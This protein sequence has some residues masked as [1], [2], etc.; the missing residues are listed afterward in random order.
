MALAAEMRMSSEDKKT[1]AQ[2]QDPQL[3]NGLAMALDAAQLGIWELDFASGNIRRSLKHDQIFGYDTLQPTW[4][5]MDSWRH[6]RPEDKAAVEQSYK[7]AL[8]TGFWRAHFYIDRNDGESRPITLSATVLYDVRGKPERMIGVISEDKDINRDTP[9]SLEVLA[10]SEALKRSQQA[11]RQNEHFTQTVLNSVADGVVVYDRDL[12]Y[13][14]WNRAMSMATGISSEQIIGRNVQEVFPQLLAEGV[15]DLLHRALQGENIRSGDRPFIVP[16]TGEK[17][18]VQSIFSPHFDA[19]GEIIGVV[20]II[21]NVTERRLAEENLIKLKS[22][23]IARVQAE[24]AQHKISTILQSITDAFFAIDN[25]FRFTYVNPRAAQFLR[26][27]ADELLGQDLREMFPT[28]VEHEDFHYLRKAMETRAPV[29][30]ESRLPHNKGWLA[31]RIYPSGEGLSVYSH[32]LTR[33]K[34]AEARLRASEERFRAVTENSPD[35]IVVIEPSG[36]IQYASPSAEALLG[37]SPEELEDR[38]LFKMFPSEASHTLRNNLLLLMYEPE[39]KITLELEITR[40]GEQDICLDI[41]ANNLFT[42]PDETSGILLTMR[43]ITRAKHH[44]KELVEARK[45][46]EQMNRLKSSLLANMSHEIHT[47]LTSLLAQA[48]LLAAEIPDKYRDAIERIERGARRLADTFGSVLALAQLEG[49]ALGIERESF[50]LVREVQ[51]VLQ[52]HEK[53]AHRKNLTLRIKSDHKEIPIYTDPLYIDR[54]LNSLVDN[55]IKFTEQ[56]E[57]L[58]ELTTSGPQ[59]EIIVRDTGIGIHPEF[60]PQLFDEF[61]QESTGLS[62]MHEGSGLGLAITKRMVEALGGTINVTSEPGVGSS[63]RVRLLTQPVENRSLQKSRRRMLAQQEAVSRRILNNGNGNGQSKR[64]NRVLLV[65]DNEDIRPLLEQLLKKVGEVDAFSNA[66]AA[67]ECAAR[68]NYDIVLMD[69]SLPK[70][71]GLEAMLKLRSMHEYD[72]VAV[73]A[74]TGHAIPGDR[75]RF[76]QA[77]FDAYIAKPFAPSE[78]VSMVEAWI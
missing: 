38:N 36:L 76:L 10:R 2:P 3:L 21:H 77:G 71:S 35:I 4:N 50:D 29:K 31:I 23:E 73:I 9:N 6:I 45:K 78:L 62:R 27:S 1:G 63:F 43:D 13:V 16:A 72:N 34:R 53:A 39:K 22:E 25:N 58:I 41:R 75:E 20:G 26:R 7:E 40:P 68:T 19:D 57:V 60:L 15:L 24:E 59:V 51:A 32:D 37:Y 67:L 52:E 56:G 5:Q 30:F 49:S 42:H 70:M 17:I 55:A 44:Q 12:R 28:I 48:N 14:A 18:W 66:E 69:I 74:M 8:V 11:L 46:A 61:R 33:Q 47:P 54:V 64:T 65:E